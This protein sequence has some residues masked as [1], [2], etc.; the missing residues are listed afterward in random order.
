MGS[1][2]AD[3]MDKEILAMLV[4]G[5]HV[6]MELRVSRGM[7]PHEPLRLADLVAAIVAILACEPWFPRKWEPAAEGKAVHEGGTIERLGSHRYVYRAQ[8]AHPLDPKVLA[9]RTERVFFS[10]AAAARHYLRWDLNLPGNL[11]GYKVVK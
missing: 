5:E 1:D 3:S 9:D 8:R 4:R 2:S 7:W 11:D 10:A 6:G